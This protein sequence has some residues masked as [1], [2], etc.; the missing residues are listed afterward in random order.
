MA[1][2][3]N[4]PLLDYVDDSEPERKRIKLEHEAAKTKKRRTRRKPDQNGSRPFNH[5][6]KPYC[7]TR[8]D[9]DTGG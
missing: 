7:L 8:G 6:P 4:S 3:E 2:Q 1:F 9:I 5:A